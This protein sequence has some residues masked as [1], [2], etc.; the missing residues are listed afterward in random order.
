MRRAHGPSTD[1]VARSAGVF[2]PA[3]YR[4]VRNKR[5]VCGA[6]ADRVTEQVARAAPR[7][8]R[9]PGTRADRVYGVLSVRLDAAAGADG[10]RFGQ[11]A[12]AGAAALG[13]GRS[14]GSPDVPCGW[15]PLVTAAG[16]RPR[17]GPAVHAVPARSTPGSGGP[18][19]GAGPA[20]HAPPP[21]HAGPGRPVVVPGRWQGGGGGARG[22]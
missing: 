13:A 19:P 5:D 8:W 10:A 20:A 1:L 9:A 15:V 6:V 17:T 3:L 4:Y 7:P 16:C 12:T 21:V 11:G 14:A 22:G 18:V 2:R